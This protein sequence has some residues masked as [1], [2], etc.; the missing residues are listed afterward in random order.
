MLQN[1][2]FF[3]KCPQKAVILHRKLT[4]IVKFNILIYGTII[5]WFYDPDRIDQS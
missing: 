5:Y 1:I 3:L 2:T 4:I